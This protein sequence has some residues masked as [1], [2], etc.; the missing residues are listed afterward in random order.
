MAKHG[1]LQAPI[2]PSNAYK[3]AL[4]KLASSCG[5]HTPQK[6]ALHAGFEMIQLEILPLLLLQ[7]YMAGTRL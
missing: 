5:H 1:T 2:A 4:A 3:K 6:H 7:V